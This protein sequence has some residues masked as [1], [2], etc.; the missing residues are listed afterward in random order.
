MPKGSTYFSP[1]KLGAMEV[2]SKGD[3]LLYC[4]MQA[5]IAGTLALLAYRLSPAGFNILSG[6]SVVIIYLGLAALLPHRFMT[7]G[8]SIN[9][10][11]LRPLHHYIAINS[12]KWLCLILSIV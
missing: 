9:R 11:S 12:A 8:A 10:C 2:T 4:L 6:T 5:P 7:L 3:F 1:K